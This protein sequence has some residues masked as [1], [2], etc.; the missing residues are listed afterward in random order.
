M[1]D[2]SEP[3]RVNLSSLRSRPLDKDLSESHG[4]GSARKQEGGKLSLGGKE[5]SEGESTTEVPWSSVLWENSRSQCGATSRIFPAEDRVLKS[6]ST[7]LPS[8]L[9][10]GLKPASEVGVII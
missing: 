4:R 5:D 6:L 2:A 1:K 7:P 3:Y 10:G 8:V 9:L